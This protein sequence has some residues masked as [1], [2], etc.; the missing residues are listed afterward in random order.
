MFRDKR[1]LLAVTGSIAA[2]KA[3][4][5]IRLLIKAG[6]AV[7][8]CMT[9]E[10]AEFITPLTLSTL[11][12]NPV[13][14]SFTKGEQGQDTWDS[15][16]ELGLWA[17]YMLVAPLTANTLAKM[18]HGQS[19]NFLIATYLSARCPVFVAPAMDLDMYQHPTTRSNL[20]LLAR[21]GDRLIPSAYG[22]LASGL[23]G[24][25][26][27]AAPEAI[28]DH[29]EAAILDGQPLH[30]K[31]VLITAGPTHEPID[32]VRFIGNRSS[33]KMGFALAREALELGARVTVVLGPVPPRFTARG[34][35]LIPVQTASQM[36]EETQRCFPQSDIFIA[37]AA[38]SDYRPRTF[39]AQKIKRTKAGLSLELVEN[40]DIL[41][42]MGA[43]R[44]SQIIVGF[45]L[46]TEQEQENAM[47]KLMDKKADCIVL[48][49]L[50][51]AG[52]GFSHETNKIQLID[53]SGEKIAFGLKPKREVARDIFK[54]IVRKYCAADEELA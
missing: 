51:D 42:A 53:R 44:Q 10:A 9:P 48:N 17:D 28:L 43:Q 31:R 24:R 32:P 15:H 14:R 25:G 39:S 37:A 22:E 47:R 4:E 6:A 54:F 41:E 35:E 34:L 1:V 23:V 20:E 18:A 27:M 36:L 45:A 2:Y 16:V 7:R 52:A 29:M 19:D 38:V 50:R 5:L 21:H 3:A 13:H 30:G 11:S 26:R 33:G 46:E 40:P 49:S 8:V 12:K